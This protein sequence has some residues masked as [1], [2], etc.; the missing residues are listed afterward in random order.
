MPPSRLGGSTPPAPTKP[1]MAEIPDAHGLGPCSFGSGSG[2]LSAGTIL[3]AKIVYMS[4]ANDTRRAAHRRKVVNRYK[5]IKGCADCGYKNHWDALEFDHLDNSKKRHTV[6]SLMH[7]SWNTIKT[8]MAKCVIRC[9]NCH[10]IRTRA[11][12]RELG[13]DPSK[14]RLV[15]A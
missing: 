15:A 6:A 5:R 14:Y 11:R 1:R 8:E 3:S 12:E 10:A 13:I 7:C 2:N 4:G 9:A